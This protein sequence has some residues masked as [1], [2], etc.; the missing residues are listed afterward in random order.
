MKIGIIGAGHIGGTLTRRF[1]ALG[2][3][4]FVANSRGPDTL[5]DLAAET[6]A[7]AVTVKEA[8]RAGEVVVVT[9]PEKNIPKLPRDLFA[10]SPANV[11]VVDTGNYYPQ[12]D[13]RIDA[14]EQGTTESRWVAQQLGH[15]VV[16]AFNTIYA[17]HL[18]ELGRP[19]GTTGRIALPVAGDDKEAKAVVLRLIDELGFD[20]V[21]AGGLD[22]SWRQ[23]PGTPVYGTDLDADGVRRALSEAKS[24]RQPNFRAA[25]STSAASTARRSV[26]DPGDEPTRST[27]S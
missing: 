8:A 13:G 11:V 12:R 16:K 17:K 9:I 21:D 18:L 10:N 23:Q 24:E 19:A 3:S 6:G 15:P 27:A 20:G 25:A 26:G 2:H 22:E 7:A 14:I 5:A 4:V 1:T